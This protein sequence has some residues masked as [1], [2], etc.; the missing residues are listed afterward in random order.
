MA[1]SYTSSGLIIQVT[2]ENSGTWG[3]FTDT[4][5]QIINGLATGFVII[6]LSSTDVVIPSIQGVND[7]GKNTIIQTT[8]TLSANV[9]LILPTV[10]RR[11]TINNATTGAFTLTVKTALGT[12]IIVPQGTVMQLYCD[13]INIL[14]ELTAIQG[15]LSLGTALAI[16][17]GGTGGNTQVAAQTALGVLV[18]TNVQP[19]SANTVLTNVVNLYTAQQNFGMATLTDAATI[20]WNL[21]TQQVAQVS[22]AGNRT[23]AN[24]TNMVA[25][26]TYIAFIRQT[27]GNN[28]LI[29][30]SAYHFNQGTPVLSTTADAVD[31]LT[32]I[33][34]GTVMYS[35]L[36]KGW[37]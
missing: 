32:A 11:W 26:A 18:G 13:N 4:N 34:D 30:S 9:N 24:P 17:N 27:E 35:S 8:G 31:I 25:G 15:P 6:A 36:A 19:Y 33:S 14:E 2:G 5:I 7:Q 20:T 1:N 21:N 22:L 12:G 29:Y 28:T 23:L 37:S 3:T 16:S 10:S